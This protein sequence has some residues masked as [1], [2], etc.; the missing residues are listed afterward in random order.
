MAGGNSVSAI[1]KMLSVETVFIA[2]GC[3]VTDCYNKTYTIN[4]YR[5]ICM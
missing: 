1:P 4:M 5:F 3:K 2:T